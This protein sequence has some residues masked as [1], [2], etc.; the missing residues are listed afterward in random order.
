MLFSVIIPVYNVE[1][2]IDECI[3]SVLNQS[4]NDWEI[5]LVDDGSTDSSGQICDKYA[6]EYPEKIKVFHKKNEGQILTRTYGI[7]N[8]QGEYFV[9]LDSDDMLKNDC[10]EKLGSVIEN[11]NSDMIIYKY[12]KSPEFT[13]E[14]T[15]PLV[16]GCLKKQNIYNLICT[17]MFLNNMCTKCVKRDCCDIE[18]DYSKYSFIK[19]AEDALQSLPIIDKC[20]KP[21]YLDEALYYYR[22]NNN[23]ITHT[24]QKN[25]AKS[26]KTVM[27]I[28]EAYSKKW[29]VDED[30]VSF[31][32]TEVSYKMYVYI[33]SSKLSVLNKIKKFF[34]LSDDDFYHLKYNP[35]FLKELDIKHK[36]LYLF[37]AALCKIQGIVRK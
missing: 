13:D 12:S 36:M 2:Y 3:Q 20:R 9:F 11:T 16:P 15:L 34:M 32:I 21:Y 25:R 7:K 1:K 8:A 35:K 28:L 24:Y 14:Y 37:V 10:L 29:S 4:F 33:A 6:L 19:N 23:S 31:F 30:E 27:R 22:T 17:S 5:I 18:A 26:I